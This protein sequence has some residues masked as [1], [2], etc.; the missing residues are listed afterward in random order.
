MWYYLNAFVPFLATFTIAIPEFFTFWGWVFGIGDKYGNYTDNGNNFWYLFLL[1]L[2]DN[3]GMQQFFNVWS[4]KGILY[5]L[6]FIWAMNFTG[7]W[8][9]IIILLSP[10]ILQQVKYVV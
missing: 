4:W 7:Y 10:I 9:N 1:S 6:L 8:S 3:W 5:Y 2:G